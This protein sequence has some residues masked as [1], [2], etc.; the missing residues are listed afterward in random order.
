MSAET[1]C[2]AVE[3]PQGFRKL[4]PLALQ[5]APSGAKGLKGLRTTPRPT[6][7][8]FLFVLLLALTVCTRLGSSSLYEGASAASDYGSNFFM[9]TPWSGESRSVRQIDLDA[10]GVDEI[11]VGGRPRACNGQIYQLSLFVRDPSSNRYAQ[12]DY[13]KNQFFLGLNFYAFYFEPLRRT[14]SA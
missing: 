1:R 14:G 2:R 13:G 6:L 12:R 8:R 5:S 7:C 10:D 9:R 11:L 3:N 4:P